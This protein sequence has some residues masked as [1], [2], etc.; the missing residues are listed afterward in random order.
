MNLTRFAAIRTIIL[1][2]HAQANVVL[3]LAQVAILVAGTL[4]FALVA[5]YANDVF[6]HGLLLKPI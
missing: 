1:P 6:S 2:I 3:R 5:Q 4:R